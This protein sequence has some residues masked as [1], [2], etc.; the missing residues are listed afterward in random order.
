MVEFHHNSTNE[1]F[2]YTNCEKIINYISSDYPNYYITHATIYPDQQVRKVLSKQKLSNNFALIWCHQ[3]KPNLIYNSSNRRC[4]A[5]RVGDDYSNSGD[6]RT[7]DYP[8]SS[9]LAAAIPL[10]MN[11][12]R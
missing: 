11:K 12:T 2:N 5:G 9:K 6:Y 10:R 3:S 1:L 7:T 4:P 8:P